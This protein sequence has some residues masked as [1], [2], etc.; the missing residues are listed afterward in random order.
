MNR[1]TA[2]RQRVREQLVMSVS[3]CACVF[4]YLRLEQGVVAKEKFLVELLVQGLDNEDDDVRDD[5]VGGVNDTDSGFSFCL[6]C[7]L[8][9]RSVVIAICDFACSGW[10]G[11]RRRSIPDVAHGGAMGSRMR[12]ANQILFQLGVVQI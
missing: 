11:I 8:E 6:R 4:V 12:F 3:A 5:G 9:L 10:L 1:G 7:Q 2:T